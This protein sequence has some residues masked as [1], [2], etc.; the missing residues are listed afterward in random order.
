MT[1]TEQVSFHQAALHIH[2]VLDD[3]AISPELFKC[4]QTEIFLEKNLF[5]RVIEYPR[6][7]LIDLVQKVYALFEYYI[8]GRDHSPEGRR[9]AYKIEFLQT[10]DAYK[11]LDLM[12]MIAVLH[13]QS[14]ISVDETLIVLKDRLPE[15]I[16]DALEVNEF[17]AQ[18]PTK[19]VYRMVSPRLEFQRRLLA[20]ALKVQ[21]WGRYLQGLVA[22]SHVDHPPESDEV[23]K[24]WNQLPFSFRSAALSRGF[25]L[26]P[27]NA[28]IVSNQAQDLLASLP[29]QFLNRLKIQNEEAE[30]DGT[31]IANMRELSRCYFADFIFIQDDLSPVDLGRGY[32]EEFL[33]FPVELQQQFLT[34]TLEQAEE[35]CYPAENPFMKSGVLV[36]DEEQLAIF[37]LGMMSMFIPNQINSYL[38]MSIREAFKIADI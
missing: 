2:Q 14:G 11:R 16:R 20:E 12:G 4:I 1:V 26:H 15:V 7:T 28:Q 27:I 22:L 32:F 17:T 37:R 23:L 30:D 6:R 18:S 34:S 29:S 9:E 38:V 36:S 25:E 24:L 3:D 8:L 19:A 13:M 33:K 21:D 5:S 10:N 35:L 31:R